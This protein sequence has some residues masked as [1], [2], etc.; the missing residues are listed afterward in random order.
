MSL[1]ILGRDLLWLTLFMN[2][3]VIIIIVTYYWHSRHKGSNYLGKDDV[4]LRY[5]IQKQVDW[6]GQI[7]GYECLL[8]TKQADGSWV[9]PEHLE[10][11]PLQRV[12]KLLEE[13]SDA[14]PLEPY[15]L[16]INLD[17][18]QI[19]SR[20]FL[21]F[22][23]WSVTRINSM[24]LTVEYTPKNN[25]NHINQ[26][27]LARQ[28]KAARAFG[29]KFAIDNVDSSLTSLKKID[30]LLPQIDILKCS[31]SSFR[32]E[33]P[34]EWLDLNLQFW[35]KLAQEHQIELVLV[36]VENEDDQALA[37]QLKIE[38]RQGFS[39][40]KPENIQSRKVD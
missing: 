15:N 14:L 40:G 39:F 35:N 17:Y 9:L 19:M 37:D 10:S 21:Y 24:T 11:I 1:Q 22:V 26:L 36:G 31:M 29:M 32:K 18:N 7:I 25:Q 12:I 34:D 30:W 2:I 27:Q 3:I 4:N 5:F 20:D 16:S 6:R 23:R 8:R 13:T 38:V 33:T 28:L